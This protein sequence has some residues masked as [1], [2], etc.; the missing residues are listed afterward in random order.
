MDWIKV[1]VK[2]AEYDMSAAPDNIFRAWIMIMIYVAAIERKPSREELCGRHVET[3]LI[4]LENWLKKTGT[5][6]DEIIDKVL[7]DVDAINS[8]KSHNRKYMQKKRV[9]TTSPPRGNLVVGKRREEKRRYNKDSI[10]EQ[11]FGKLAKKNAVIDFLK[12]NPKAVW[13]TVRAFLTNRYKDGAKVYAE[14]EIE[15]LRS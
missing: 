5:T 2:H 8:R 11:K 4:S 6:L 14:C 3:T 1:K 12:E 9:D 7:E 15:A 13:P 10:L